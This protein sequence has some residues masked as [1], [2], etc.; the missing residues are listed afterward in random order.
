M[1]QLLLE[2]FYEHR[3]TR[4]L[5]TSSPPIVSCHCASEQVPVMLYWHVQADDDKFNRKNFQ[6]TEISMNSSA[7]VICIATV[8]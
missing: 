7:R 1:M 8:G 5:Q 4:Q 2:R 6:V 3:K